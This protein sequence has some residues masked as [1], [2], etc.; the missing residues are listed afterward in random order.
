MLHDQNPSTTPPGSNDES[1]VAV[2]DIPEVRDIQALSPPPSSQGR[3][4][5]QESWEAGSHH[6]STLSEQFSTMSRE[7]NAMGFW[8][9]GDGEDDFVET[10]P[11][12]I[13]PDNNPIVS[14]RI[15][16]P[17][18]ARSE[19]E[20]PVMVVQVKKEETETKIA[21]WQSE[22]IAKVNNRFKRE[23]V[24]INSWE[25]EQVEVATARLKKIERKLEEQR[26]KALEKTQNTVAKAHRKAEERR[27]S[28]EAKRDLKVAKVLELAN[29]MRAVGRVPTK[30]SFF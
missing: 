12:A 28:A 23:E 27:A 20:A 18:V 9:R 17:E 25:N 13:V 11:L 26:A 16:E 21:A 7:F 24:V 30:R 19:G 3:P 2:V 6:S 29:F 1:D 22:E 15:T 10:N 4:R 14:S 5:R 8:E